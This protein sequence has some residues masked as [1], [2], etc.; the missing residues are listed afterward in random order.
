MNELRIEFLD[1]WLQLLERHGFD[2]AALV[3]S[4]LGARLLS[5]VV[6]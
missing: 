5:E 3:T 6:F 4:E 1:E 2:P